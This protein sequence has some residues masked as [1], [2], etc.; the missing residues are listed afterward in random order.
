MER[1]RLS[2]A[3]EPSG[4]ITAGR[5]VR[6][7]LEM[8]RPTLGVVEARGEPSDELLGGAIAE[9]EFGTG[10]KMVPQIKNNMITKAS[11][12]N[13]FTGDTRSWNCEF[14]IGLFWVLVETTR[15]VALREI[16]C[17]S[18]RKTGTER[19]A[20]LLIMIVSEKA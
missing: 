6:S 11:L 3:V 5:R 12:E 15:C 19:G 16:Q 14:G 8:L 18:S 1:L 9:L 13:R 7:V 10:T 4:R 17:G 2:L 20:N